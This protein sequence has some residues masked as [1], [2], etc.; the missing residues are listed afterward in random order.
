M[1]LSQIIYSNIQPIRVR[2]PEATFDA[3]FNKLSKDCDRLEIAVGYVSQASLEELRDLV[4]K[5]S[6]KKVCLN[7]GM[8]AIEGIPIRTLGLAKTIDSE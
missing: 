1:P 6:I 3:V 8:Y 5:Y 4:K 2:H 7:L